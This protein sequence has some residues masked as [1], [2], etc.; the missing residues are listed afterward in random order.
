MKVAFYISDHGFGHITRNLQVARELLDRDYEVLIVTGQRQCLIAS[1][2]LRNRAQTVICNTDAGLAVQPG[3]I[4]ID[5][6]TT[7]KKVRNHV[8]SWNERISECVDADVY[9]VDIV[10]WSLLGARKKGIPSILMT[11]FTWIEQYEPFLPHELLDCYKNAFSLADRVFY[12]ELANPSC[13]KF[14]GDGIDVGFAAREINSDEAARIRSRFNRPVVFI[15]LGMSNS[16]LAQEFSVDAL[17]YD[18]I[19]TS[20]VNLTGSN[21]VRLSPDNPN[22]QDFIAASDFCICKAGWSTVAEAMIAGVPFAALN[23]PDVAED[24]MTISM[25]E[26]RGCGIGV[27]IE[28]L[29]HIEEIIQRLKKLNGVEKHKNNSRMIADLIVGAE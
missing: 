23:R 21:V 11:S 19:V 1:D 15:S 8:S 28:E 6:Q 16:G 22:T 12:Y 5:V 10:P 7:I 26:Q 27:E 2:Y 29:N 20:T 24:T 13:R 17:P 25:L 9:V 18:F 4:S 3:E 14:L